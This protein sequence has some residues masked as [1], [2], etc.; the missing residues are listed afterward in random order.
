[1]LSRI[2]DRNKPTLAVPHQLYGAVM[3]QARL[4]VF[5]TDYEFSDTVMGRLD[6]LILHVFLL[7]HR[8]GLEGQAKAG[9]LSQEVFDCFVDNLD[10]ALR[11]IGIGDSGVPKKK[12]KL[13]RSFYGSVEDFNAPLKSRDEAVLAK[14]ISKRFFDSGKSDISSQLAKYCCAAIDQLAKDEIDGFYRGELSWVA[15]PNISS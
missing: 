10:T 7:S 3:A 4:P 2:F 13:V 5:F 14:A 12:K 1:M 15:V 9:N 11:E 8:L 6:V